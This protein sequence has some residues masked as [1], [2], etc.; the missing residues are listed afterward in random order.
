[1]PYLSRRRS[2]LLTQSEVSLNINYL[3]GRNVHNFVKKD[4]H[5]S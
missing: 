1:M 3:R 4:R 2:K 5:Y